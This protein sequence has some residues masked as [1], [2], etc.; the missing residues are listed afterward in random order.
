MSQGHLRSGRALC[1]LPNYFKANGLPLLK[2]SYLSSPGQVLLS[3]QTCQYQNGLTKTTLTFPIYVS[4][5]ESVP[6]ESQLPSPW[7]CHLKL[8]SSGKMVCRPWIHRIFQSTAQ[9]FSMKAFGNEES[10][11]NIMWCFMF[12]FAAYLSFVVSVHMAQTY[13]VRDGSKD[14]PHHTYGFAHHKVRTYEYAHVSFPLLWLTLHLFN[15]Q[16]KSMECL[17]SIPLISM[18]TTVKNSKAFG[19]YTSFPTFS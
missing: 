9:P 18:K 2:L 10:N 12:F 19:I 11:I 14:F 5:P 6:V 8:I 13:K 4:S 17:L 3:L 1:L 7:W 16:A 15:Q